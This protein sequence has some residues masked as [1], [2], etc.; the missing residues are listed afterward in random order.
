MLPALLE[1][2]AVSACSE[3][4]K[5]PTVIRCWREEICLTTSRLGVVQLSRSLTHPEPKPWPRCP[6]MHSCKCSSASLKSVTLG[7]HSNDLE[8]LPKDCYSYL[9]HQKSSSGAFP[10]T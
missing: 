10:Q 2:G 3:D 7:A 8:W 5:T 6:Y 4:I 9:I 1:P